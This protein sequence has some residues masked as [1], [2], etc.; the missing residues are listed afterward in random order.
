M[1][2]N[3]VT[4]ASD[5]TYQQVPQD[6]SGA[7]LSELTEPLSYY[8]MLLSDFDTNDFSQVSRASDASYNQSSRA[9]NASYNPASRSSDSSYNQ[10]TRP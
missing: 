1:T 2:W 6:V 8:T 10:I 4:R 3:P 7:I 9:S 5:T